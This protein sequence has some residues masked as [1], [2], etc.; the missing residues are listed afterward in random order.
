V[1]PSFALTSCLLALSASLVA[2]PASAALRSPQVP[3]VGGILQA[4]LNSVGEHITV[5]TDQWDIQH[6]T[7][8]NDRPTYTVTIEL[9]PK[10]PGIAVGFYDA[11]EPSP[12][13]YE[14]FPADAAAGW[15][16][17]LSFRSEPVRAIVSLFDESASFRGSHVYLGPDRSAFSYYLSGPDGV[18]YVE[19]SRNPD[20]HAQFLVYAGTYINAGAWWIAGEESSIAGS[21]S[22]QD[23]DDVILYIGYDSCQ[24]SPTVASTWGALKAHFR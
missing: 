20:G 22:D 11:D 8:R 12:A 19:D 23:Y 4:Y 14:L 24:C 7:G 13:L 18:F 9:G 2:R 6:W 21:E 16:A 10:A 3:V 15:F 5:G 17:V 1:R